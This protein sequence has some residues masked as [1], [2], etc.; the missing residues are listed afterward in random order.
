MNCDKLLRNFETVRS[1]K[2]LD[3]RKNNIYF[4]TGFPTGH[5][6]L[7]NDLL[8]KDLTE[9]DECRLCEKERTPIHFV[10]NIARLKKEY[11]RQKL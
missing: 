2:K 11:F 10:T 5:C 3:L 9:T 7:E 6:Y 1:K 4:F 8:K